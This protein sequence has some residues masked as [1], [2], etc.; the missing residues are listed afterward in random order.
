MQAVF[1]LSLITFYPL[2][3]NILLGAGNPLNRQKVR[4]AMTPTQEKDLQDLFMKYGNPST[5]SDVRM[6]IYMIHPDALNELD[7]VLYY[8]N[9]AVDAIKEFE[10][11]IE[12]LKAYRIALAERYNYLATAP[13]QPVVRLKRE[14]RH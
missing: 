11:K 10:R 9:K 8:D 4:K 12:Q 1:S 14:R 3:N 6:S 13:T 5:E 7:K 2:H